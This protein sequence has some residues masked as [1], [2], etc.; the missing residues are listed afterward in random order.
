MGTWALFPGWQQCLLALNL[1]WLLLLSKEL[2]NAV[3]TNAQAPTALIKPILSSNGEFRQRN[4]VLTNCQ[5]L[6][7]YYITFQLITLGSFG[8]TASLYGE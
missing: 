2:D 8:L 6:T 7:A 4:E 5:F 3:Y 1:P